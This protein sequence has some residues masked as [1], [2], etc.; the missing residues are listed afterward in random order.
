MSIWKRK[1]TT[2]MSMYVHM[3]VIACFFEECL[4]STP[5]PNSLFPELL[6]Q[7]KFKPEARFGSQR[8]C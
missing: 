3:C 2:F 4:F 6:T 1:Q 8:K 7:V 5:T